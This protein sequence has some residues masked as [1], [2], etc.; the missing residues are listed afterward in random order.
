MSGKNA[1]CNTCTIRL[2]ELCYQRVWWFRIFREPLVMGMRFLGRV[3]R[4]DVDE[5]E[6]RSE[7]C[8]RC[9]R[10]LKTGL[11]DKSGL[12]RCLN[13]VIDP[14]FN[15]VRNSIVTDQELRESRNLA[16]ERQGLGS[17]VSKGD[18]SL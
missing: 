7:E 14:L 16:Q 4:V 11:K 15:R 17:E 5:Y 9:I 12:F 8:Q 3:Y 6:V 10:F 1:V 13:G 18:G 2:V